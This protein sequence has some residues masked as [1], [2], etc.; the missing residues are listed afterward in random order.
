MSALKPMFL[1]SH[2]F[3]SI[4]LGLLFNVLRPGKRSSV[5]SYGVKHCVQLLHYDTYAMRTYV[6]RKSL[7]LQLRNLHGHVYLACVKINRKGNTCL[8]AEQI[9]T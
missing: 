9:Y 6:S 8:F 3:P 7:L 1:D 4:F 5:D 2:S